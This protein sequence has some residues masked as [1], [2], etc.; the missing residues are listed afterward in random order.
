MLSIC[1]YA[2]GLYPGVHQHSQRHQ[3]SQLDCPCRESGV[4]SLDDRGPDESD[5][6]PADILLLGVDLYQLVCDNLIPID[7]NYC[8]KQRERSFYSG[9][10]F[11]DGE[12]YG[13][14]HSVHYRA[15][16]SLHNA[17]QQQPNSV[18]PV[19]THGKY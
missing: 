3:Y 15:F 14:L 16:H 13:F 5:K 9:D 12:F 11:A 17:Q 19:L 18:L 6:F 1:Q 4:I 10:N 7:S 8:D 2:L